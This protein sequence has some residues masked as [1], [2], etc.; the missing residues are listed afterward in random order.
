MEQGGRGVTTRAGNGRIR[1]WPASSSRIPDLAGLAND[2]RRKRPADAPRKRPCCSNRHAFDGQRLSRPRR[3]ASRAAALRS[4][5]VL[6][7]R[8]ACGRERVACPR[9]VR[10]MLLTLAGDRGVRA[11]PV[12]AAAGKA[13]IAGPAALVALDADRCCACGLRGGHARDGAIFFF[14]VAYRRGAGT[15]QLPLLRRRCAIVDLRVRRAPPRAW[16]LA[17]GTAFPG[18][19]V[20]P[21]AGPGPVLDC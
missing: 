2:R 9:R 3:R 20:R 8:G 14:F 17:V 18:G 4:H 16:V 21:A 12:S 13:N 6:C 5:R 1:R 15:S 10:A 7:G 11:G 19:G